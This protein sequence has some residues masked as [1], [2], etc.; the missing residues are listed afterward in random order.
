MSLQHQ[1]FITVRGNARTYRF[2]Q[3]RK[4]FRIEVFVVTLC[5]LV[6]LTGEGMTVPS[7]YCSYTVYILY[8]P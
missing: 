3:P 1:C 6:L 7:L 4:I 8:I 2:F 5:I